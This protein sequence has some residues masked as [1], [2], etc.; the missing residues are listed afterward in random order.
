MAQIAIKGIKLTSISI[1]LEK[2]EEIAS[3][4]QIIS[5]IDKV[6]AKQDVGGYNGIKVE[7][8]PAT[9]KALAEFIKCYKKDIC[10]TIGLDT[11]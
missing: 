4:Y 7:K 11:E 3:H 8:S 2:E 1:S 10:D 5:T 9:C 6:L